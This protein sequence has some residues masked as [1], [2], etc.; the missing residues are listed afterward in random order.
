MEHILEYDE[1]NDFLRMKIP[2]DWKFDIRNASSFLELVEEYYEGRTHRYLVVDVSE[3]PGRSLS[4]EFRTWMNEQATRIGFEKIGVVGVSPFNRMV[5]K[6]AIAT[7]G[8]SKQTQFFK[9]E[10]EAIRWLSVE[11]LVGAAR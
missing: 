4:R 6:I 1:E 2:S 5:A 9:S 10:R 8:K 7:M 11:D 3:S